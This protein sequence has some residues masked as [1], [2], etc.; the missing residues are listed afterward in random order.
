MLETHQEKLR[1]FLLET[2]RVKFAAH[3]ASDEEIRE[4]YEDALSF[5]ES[6]RPTPTETAAVE[7]EGECA[8][9]QAA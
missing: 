5:V 9:E 1:R 8:E 6:T 4:A 7:A 3:E 2:D